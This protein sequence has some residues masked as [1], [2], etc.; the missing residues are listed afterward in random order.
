VLPPERATIRR[1]LFFLPPILTI[2]LAPAGP[3]RATEP[4]DPFPLRSQLPFNLMFLDQKPASGRILAPRR[5]RFSL[6]FAYE[7]TFAASD[8]LVDMF[9]QDGFATYGGKVTLPLLQSAAAGSP[10]RTAF[11]LDGE[12]LR[13]VLDAG[14]GVGPRL[15]LGAEVPLISHRGGFLDSAID[16]YHDRLN[17]PDGGRTVFAR[18]LFR[19]GYVGGGESV[20]FD[21]GTGG[22]GLGDVVL[23]GKTL[24]VRG[25]RSVPSIAASFS[26]K[27]PTG[28]PDRLHGSG[29]TDFGASLYLTGRFGRSSLH[30]AYGYASLGRW[31]I[32]PGLL[33][34]NPRSLSAT[35][36]YAATPESHLILQFLRSTGPFRYRTGS[37]LGRVAMEVA[38]GFRHRVRGD[39]HLEWAVLENLSRSL[40]TPDFGLFLGLSSRG[41]LAGGPPERPDRFH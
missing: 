21:R 27:L 18:D 40:N 10:G 32:A 13:V 34:L 26:V 2:L 15:E 17:L 4:D 14:I 20:F 11:V 33:L 6:S 41:A 23:T 39:L 16:S 22:I 5:T 31:E 28:D 7:S 12:T 37:D 8:D 29:G 9:R 24:L 25:R 36:A 1:V 30:G 3:A 38:V 35:Y 19:A